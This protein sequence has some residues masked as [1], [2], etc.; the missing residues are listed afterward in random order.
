MNN[1]NWHELWLYILININSL[2]QSIPVHVYIILAIA[3][4][5]GIT[6]VCSL[7]TVEHKG[8]LIWLLLLVEY[9]VLIFCTT[10]F[11]RPVQESKAF[12]FRLLWGFQAFLN[13]Q[14]AVMAEK[15]M[16]LVVFI[17]VGFLIRV[18]SRRFKWYYVLLFT[19]LL[20]LSIEFLQFVLARGYAEVDDVILNTLGALLGFGLYCIVLLLGY[21]ERR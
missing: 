15:I 17:P 13:G 18:T 3:L 21:G 4:L 8:K 11:L 10:V 19:V 20:S 14:N 6:L 5:I 2:F 1:L 7:K 12:D 16:N 9:V